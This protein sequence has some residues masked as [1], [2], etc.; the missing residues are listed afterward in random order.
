M[1]RITTILQRFGLIKEKKDRP[2]IFMEW[3]FF[4]I[5]TLVLGFM[6][7]QSLYVNSSLREPLRFILFTILMII[8]IVLYWLSVRLR[9]WSRVAVYIVI[10]SGLAVTIVSLGANI[11][12]L[13]GLYMGLIGETTGL[14][15]EKL[16]WMIVAVAVLLGL[17]FLNYISMVGPGWSWWVLVMLPMTFFVAVYV[18]MYSRQ[19]EARTR[20]QEL[21][22]ELESANQQLSEYAA[23]VEDLTLANERQRMARELHDIL[24]QGL[25]GLTL[26]LEAVDAHL[27][28]NHPERARSILRQSMER[29]RETLAEARQAIDNLRQDAQGNFE[30]AVRQE[31]DHFTDSTGIP[32][33]QDLEFPEKIPEQVSET[34]LRVTREGLTNIARHAKAKRASV[35][36]VTISMEDQLE[37]EI[38]DDGIGFD[39]QKVEAGHYGLLGMRERVRLAGGSIDLRSDPGNGTR[40]VIRMPLSEEKPA[41]STLETIPGAL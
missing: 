21:L 36:I 11:G 26:Q 39:S 30:E 17:S 25:A 5:L 31:I 29:A 10:Q 38:S 14:M 27:A 2:E 7:V 37:I 1:N 8:H 16:R 24:S 32:C 28:G 6:Y 23:Q 18:T 19:S 35:R 3:P 4:L 9:N 22:K 41:A 12:L 20:A 13:L 15:R 33:S 34:V 40:I